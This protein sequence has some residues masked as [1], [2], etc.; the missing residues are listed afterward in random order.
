MRLMVERAF[1]QEGEADG[2]WVRARVTSGQ[3]STYFVGYEEHWT[4]RREAEAKWGADFTLKRYHDSALSF[5]S[6]P[7]RFVG[8]LLFDRP[9]A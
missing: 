9:I 8:Q 4:L 3:L 7:A 6:P 5:G 1:Q 2:K